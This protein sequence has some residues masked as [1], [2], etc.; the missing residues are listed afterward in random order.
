MPTEIITNLNWV[1]ILV[2]AILIRAVYIGVKRGF[3][4][5]LFKL[6]GVLFAVFITLHYFSGTSKFLQD[7]LHLPQRASDLFSYGLLWAIVI[8]AFKF[9]REGFTILFKIEAHSAFD[10]WGGLLTSVMRGLLLS[11]L[12]ILFLRISAVEYFTKNLEKSFTA[13]HIVSLSPKV[14]EATYNNFVSKFFPSEELNKSVFKLTDFQS[15]KK[16]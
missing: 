16:K 12:A 1:D 3:V 4:V 14:Y 9:I 8:L 10:K 15:E 7:K 5:E 6:V 2:G 13:S 11:S